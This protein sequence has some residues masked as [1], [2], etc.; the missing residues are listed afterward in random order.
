MEKDTLSI[1]S[2]E[3]TRTLFPPGSPSDTRRRVP[4]I[5]SANWYPQRNSDPDAQLVPF[6]LEKVYSRR[7]TLF[8]GMLLRVLP[9]LLWVLRNFWPNPRIGRVQ[10]VS[11]YHDVRDVL[12]RDDVFEIPFDH[13]A[14][15]LG[16]KPNF[17][18]G[19]QDGSEYQRT[20]TDVY[21]IFKRTDIQRIQEMSSRFA[22]EILEERAET[23]RDA[24]GKSHKRIDAVGQLI[25]RVPTR[26]VEE[27]YGIGLAEYERSEFE[28][29][30]LA[31]S[32]YLFGD[33][34]KG[35]DDLPGY[36]ADAFK[37]VNKIIHRSV[38]ARRRMLQSGDGKG[39]PEDEE[40]ILERLLR[41][42]AKEPEHYTD[43]RIVSYLFGMILGFLPTNLMANGN[44]L[45]ALMKH[46][47]ERA[48]ARRAALDGDDALLCRCLFE[49]MRRRIPLNPGPW[50]RCV[51]DYALAE[52]EKLW[53]RLVRRRLLRKGTV[54]LPL[55]Q[56]AMRDSRGVRRPRSFDPDRS[57]EHNLV[58]GD[59]L[60]HCIGRHIAE[61]QITQT[62]KALLR[63]ENLRPASWPKGRMKRIS[64]FPLSQ[65]LEYEFRSSED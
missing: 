32:G 22:Y 59:G 65:T 34:G 20:R 17:L 35:S 29:C 15:K 14:E 48:Q 46:D 16:W 4:K 1:H 54:V 41:A 19:M 63:Q 3:S 11:R 51:D 60:H 42:Q 8:V 28:D 30:L 47:L 24:N 12:D 58:F 55:T 10:L 56:S 64:L 57:R 43:E 37:R 13:K 61:V 50:R 39:R 38:T 26:V 6:K 52:N 45:H 40:D 62:M 31:L 44:I 21:S 33:A 9:G 27:Y 23:V 7:R 25:R 18:L 49:T 36:A 53:D 2:A 5:L